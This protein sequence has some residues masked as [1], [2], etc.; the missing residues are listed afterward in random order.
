VRAL[1]W[2]R[3]RN[4][5]KYQKISGDKAPYVQVQTDILLDMEFM[6][7]PDRERLCFLLLLCLAGRTQNKL[8]GDAQAIMHLC[9]FDSV[10]DMSLMMSQGLIE[11]WDPS[12]HSQNV[13]KEEER[14]RYERERKK[15]YR[16]AKK[17]PGPV[18]RKSAL[19]RERETERETET[20]TNSLTSLGTETVVVDE[21]GTAPRERVASTPKGSR[22]P[23][24][25]QPSDELRTWAA[26]ERPDLD[27]ETV[28]ASFKDH[29]KAATGR[30]ASKAD[31]EA[32]FRNWVRKENP[33]RKNNP[34]NM[35]RAEA[36]ARYK[37]EQF[38]EWERR[39]G[40]Q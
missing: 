12:K 23:L 35:S 24:D 18:P 27:I 19:E 26:T 17:S 33:G 40:P 28:I 39:Y 11:E 13:D 21:A 22:L 37:D 36:N 30:T 16:D 38:D 34:A 10:P 14:K 15:Q 5:E 9:H 29:W 25:W 6:V 8:P 31:W 32:A 2:L 3:I 4:W 7:L 20:E 1:S